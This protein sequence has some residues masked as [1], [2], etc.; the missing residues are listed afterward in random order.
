MLE[1]E[2]D[3]LLLRPIMEI[4]ADVLYAGIFSDTEVTGPSH[5]PCT[6]ETICIKRLAKKAK[7]EDA[8]YLSV[9]LKQN[10]E[11]IGIICQ[12]Q[13]LFH[14]W[15]EIGFALRRTQWHKGSGSEALKGL[16]E[17]LFRTEKADRITCTCDADNSYSM[18]TMQK[19]GMHIYGSITTDAEYMTLMEIRQPSRL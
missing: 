8:Y 1:I 18:K 3:R 4:D 15:L 13:P 14:K 19:C 10:H 11:P 6:D 12:E 7:D 16:I 5:L 2:T 9:I 17:Y